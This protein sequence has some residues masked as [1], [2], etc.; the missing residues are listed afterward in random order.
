MRSFVMSA[1]RRASWPPRH[2]V[3]A[4]AFVRKGINPA[5]GK[6]C[7]LHKCE[8]CGEEFPKG[9]MRADHHEPIIPIAHQWAD[10]PHSFLGYD[11]N[12]V[13]RRLWIELGNGWNVIC[14]KCHSQITAQERIGRQFEK[15]LNDNQ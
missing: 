8:Q 9:E 11:W 5:T 14:I 1:L 2:E 12:E 7:M 4:R 13:M 15:I 10:L 3:I 6:P